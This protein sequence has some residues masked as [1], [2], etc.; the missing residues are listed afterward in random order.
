MNPPPTRLPAGLAHQI[1]SLN[2]EQRGAVFDDSDSV[3]LAGPGS[4]KTHVLVAKAAFLAF[5]A[6]H[7][8]RRIAAIT[9]SVQAAE[10]IAGRMRKTHP[11]LAKS[12]RSATVHAFCTAEILRPFMGLA[13]Q[14]SYDAHRL[15]S[16]TAEHERWARAYQEAQPNGRPGSPDQ[17]ACRTA[18]MMGEDTTRFSAALVDAVR[19]YQRQLRNDNELDYDSICGRSLHIVRTLPLAA[20]AIVARYPWLLID[21]YQDLGA[22][23]H[24]IVI[25]LRSHGARLFAV[26][27]PDQSIYGFNGSSPHHLLTLAQESGVRTHRLTTN[28]RSGR[29]LINAATAVLGQ[30]RGYEAVPDTDPGLIDHRVTNATVHG[31]ANIVVSAVQELLR[32]G[33]PPHHIAVLYRASRARLP[34]RTLLTDALTGA[35]IE[36]LTERAYKWPR[37]PVVRFL[38]KVARWHLT[39]DRPHQRLP[40][41]QFDELLDGYLELLDEH[42]HHN[43]RELHLSK[44]LHRCL[45]LSPATATTKLEEWLPHIV[46]TLEIERS[47]IVADVEELHADT[48]AEAVVGDFCGDVEATGKIVV[49][50]YHAAKGREWPYVILPGLQEGIV[51]HWSGMA[52]HEQ[53][54]GQSKVAEERRLF[55]VALSR[56]QRA[57]VLIY[58]NGPRAEFERS[59]SR[60]I[61]RLPGYEPPLSDQQYERV[62]APPAYHVDT[63]RTVHANS[64]R[65]WTPEDDHRL[66]ELARAGSTIAEMMSYFGR[67]ENAIRARLTRNGIIPS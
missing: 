67:N 53:P 61:T 7:G 55:Y 25:A 3:V 63:L 41:L 59:P 27:D 49:T 22:V 65:R 60:F 54:P 51:P 52:G 28:Y 57:A 23:L 8:P 17:V 31:H 11:R 16:E 1:L 33:I 45:R 58:A 36:T 9:Y 40:N 38:Q 26:G 14:G 39:R 56:A 46:D 2:D 64:H 34:L 24:A 37:T 47:Q 50:T 43:A 10:E 66:T 32:A 48:F 29:V 12:V 21:E 6:A 30:D 62:A 5:T 42:P 44:T 13:G 4:G 35:G 18:V 19:I 20:K 15:L